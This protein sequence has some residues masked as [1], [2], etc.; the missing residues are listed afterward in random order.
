MKRLAAEVRLQRGEADGGER[1]RSTRER[2]WRVRSSSRTT[3]TRPSSGAGSA[4]VSGGP[5][6][7]HG[8]TTESVRDEDVSEW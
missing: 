2:L 8:I 4:P 6:R 1:Y 7:V 3:R 5:R